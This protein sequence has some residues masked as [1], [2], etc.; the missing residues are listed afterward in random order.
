LGSRGKPVYALITTLEEWYA[1]GDRILRA[2]DEFVGRKLVDENIDPAILR[3][4]P[5]TICAVEDFEL[6]MQFIQ[7]AGIHTFMDKK[8]TGE[9]RLWPIDSF[10]RSSF[11]DEFA[12]VRGN[13][14]PEDWQRIHPALGKS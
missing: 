9:H 4:H 12:K 10:I 6:A 14:F 11:I 8:V 13:L 7:Q 1:F 5:Y 3:D 2:L